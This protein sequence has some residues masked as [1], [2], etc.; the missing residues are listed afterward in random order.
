MA[1]D[2]DQPSHSNYYLLALNRAF[3]E[4]H[5]T[6]NSKLT[7]TTVKTT[8]LQHQLIYAKYGMKTYYSLPWDVC[9][10]LSDYCDLRDAFFDLGL[11]K[12]TE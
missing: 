12:T 11:H 1:N 3:L 6:S 10:L 4:E 7:M 8:F 5:N 9:Y 2:L